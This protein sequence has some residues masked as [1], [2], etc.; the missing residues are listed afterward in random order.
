MAFVPGWLDSSI[1]AFLEHFPRTSAKMDFALITC[2]D[3]H[4]DPAALLRKSPELKSIAGEAKPLKTGILLPTARML[5]AEAHKQ[6]F[7]GFDEIWFFPHEKIKPKPESA[8]LV[9]PQRVDQKKL[10]QLGPWMADNDCALGLGDGDGL[11]L[12]VKARGLVKY[13]IA[14]SMSQPQPTTGGKVEK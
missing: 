9:G 13:L 3:S 10:D 12:I 11:N 6:I 7:F 5:E 1:H 4:L 8:W 2:L 14:C